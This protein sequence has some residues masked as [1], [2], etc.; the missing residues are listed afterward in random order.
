M[1]DGSPTIWTPEGLENRPVHMLVN[2]IRLLQEDLWCVHK[3]LD[4]Q[5]VPRTVG[6]NVY[7]IVGRIQQL[8]AALDAKT[9]TD[10]SGNGRG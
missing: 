5:G 10:G 7:S 9:D 8:I 6:N 2:Q 3:W 4:D 1:S